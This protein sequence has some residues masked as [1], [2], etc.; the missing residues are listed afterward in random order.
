MGTKPLQSGMGQWV[1]IEEELAL[2]QGGA[3]REP[4]V[5]IFCCRTPRSLRKLNLNLTFQVILNVYLSKV[6]R[7]NIF[8]LCFYSF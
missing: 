6:G 2:G 5:S 8:Y 3:A 7:S 1:E 4:A